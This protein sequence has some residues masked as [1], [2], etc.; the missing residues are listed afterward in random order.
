MNKYSDSVDSNLF[1]LICKKFNKNSAKLVSAAYSNSTW[2]AYE[3]AFNSFVNFE[4]CKGKDHDWP[5]TQ[6]ILN[7][8]I[9][10]TTFDKHLKNSTIVTYVASLSSV[11]Q[12]FGFEGNVFTSLTTKA[13]LRG[14]N[15]LSNTLH[16]PQHTRKVFTIYIL[17]LLGHAISTQSWEEQSKKVF[18]TCSCVAFF[19]SFRI[20]ELLA[21]KEKGYDLSTTLLWKN[22]RLKDDHCLIHIESPKSNAK[23]GEFVD[24]FSL[25]GKNCCPVS[26]LKSLADSSNRSDSSPVFSFSDGKPLTPPVFNDTLRTLLRPYLGS[27][28]DQ[29]SSHSL[30]AAIPSILATRPDLANDQDIK[31]WGRWDSPCYKRYTR[32]EVVRK[33]HIY[34]KISTAV[35]S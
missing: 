26:A 7:D 4:I 17:R 11:H 1:K 29:L 30:R 9:G 32:L 23:E 27:S 20:G 19:G 2:K 13:L 21:S 15:N 5:I 18:W 24:L 33:R 10:W 28:S 14:S 3:A 25:P 22:I 6:D 31:G 16:S 34:T 8:Y 12:L 35:F